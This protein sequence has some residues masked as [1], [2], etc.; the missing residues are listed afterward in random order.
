MSAN[1]I[2]KKLAFQSGLLLFQTLQN[3]N[4]RSQLENIASA[5]DESNILLEDINSINAEKLDEAK[6]QT[7]LL[8]LAEKRE[9]LNEARAN[10]EREVKQFVFELK[11]ELEEASNIDL[12]D[13][14]HR[15]LPLRSYVRKYQINSG[16]VDSFEDKE[17]V[18]ETLQNLD[19]AVDAIENNEDT[20]LL[21]YL[22]LSDK[23]LSIE[24]PKFDDRLQDYKWDQVE[25]IIAI[26]D[27]LLEEDI[28][29]AKIHELKTGLE[30]RESPDDV[31]CKIINQ[32][33]LE[34]RDFA[35][36]WW[37]LV[38][39]LGSGTLVWLFAGIQEGHAPMALVGFFTSAPL[40]MWL[41]KK[42]REYRDGELGLSQESRRLLGNSRQ[43]LINNIERYR[44]Y[45]V[46]RVSY[47]KHLSSLIS[48]VD[49]L[50]AEPRISDAVARSL[51]NLIT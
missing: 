3:E 20:L 11:N 43:E 1:Q 26:I 2:E 45:L 9:S 48:E 49:E 39:L 22:T 44:K 33:R 8:Q 27:Q 35:P 16:L 36:V 19:E 18:E 10:T 41:Y 23:L 50:V 38:G 30:V 47:A 32:I 6:K 17:Y 34:E 25:E 24:R 29:D 31:M 13:Q 4:L 46:L 21:R 7:A 42:R 40:Y 14:A 51:K 28:T 12:I 37:Y 15:L 5:I